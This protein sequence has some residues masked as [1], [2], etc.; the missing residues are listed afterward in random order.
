MEYLL[1]KNNLG[2]AVSPILYGS[3]IGEGEVQPK[4]LRFSKDY[5]AGFLCAKESGAIPVPV[6]DFQK[7]PLGT[8]EFERETI[9]LIASVLFYAKG[10]PDSPFEKEAALAQK[11]VEAGQSEP[12][13]LSF[14]EIHSP[15]RKE[16]LYFLRHYDAEG[17][18]IDLLQSFSVRV[19]AEGEDVDY[20]QVERTLPACIDTCG[21]FS[22]VKR[23]TMIETVGSS[24]EQGIAE[25]VLLTAIEQNSH[26]VMASAD[27]SDPSVLSLRRLFAERLGDFSLKNI[28]PVS[29]ENGG[30]VM[31]G[32]EKT[33][34]LIRNVAIRSKEG[35]L[36]Y[37]HSFRDGAGDWKS[38]NGKPLSFN[39]RGELRLEDDFIVL[40]GDY[41]DVEIEVEC[42]RLSG[43]Q[44]FTVGAG[45]REGLSYAVAVSYGKNEGGYGVSFEKWVDG[46]KVTSSFKGRDA[47]VGYSGEGNRVKLL[48]TENGLQASFYQFGAWRPI[49][50][51][52][53]SKVNERCFAS[54]TCTEDDKVFFKCVNAG[55]EEEEAKL[56]LRHFGEKTKARL[57]RFPCEQET[58]LP[59]ADN[60]LSVS[61]PP[62]SAVLLVIE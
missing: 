55:E 9:E 35:E 44:C 10:D 30:G 7:L 32:G 62:K 54:A 28:A 61:V 27:T 18:M 50:D 16:I 46:V 8:E 57:V 41:A 60:K 25:A 34:F 20:V 19:I 39:D 3:A 15:D 59:I 56:V 14:L 12:F 13:P 24:E 37:Y 1:D 49:L 43:R 21:K 6:F 52:S 58:C 23:E 40:A 31:I 53:T 38:M 26:I 42:K 4:F 36:L 11:R 5:E 48:Y 17:G 47:F 2:D 22:L 51:E 45:V 29:K 33:T